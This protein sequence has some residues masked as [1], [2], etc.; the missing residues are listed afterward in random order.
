MFLETCLY[1]N[2]VHMCQLS[3]SPEMFFH[4]EFCKLSLLSQNLN[5]TIRNDNFILVLFFNISRHQ[6]LNKQIAFFPQIKAVFQEKK[7]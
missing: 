4:C 6:N 1:S 3:V 2:D 5:F 7:H